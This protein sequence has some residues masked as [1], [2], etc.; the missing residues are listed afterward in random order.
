MYL[1]FPSNV[2]VTGTSKGERFLLSLTIEILWN[3]KTRKQ[4]SMDLKCSPH[5]KQ[6]KRKCFCKCLKTD[7]L[8]VGRVRYLI[9]EKWELSQF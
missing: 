4:F 6:I 7:I 1:F 8:E 9:G 3:F 5:A 2:C